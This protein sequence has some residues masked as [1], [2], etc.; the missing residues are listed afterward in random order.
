MVIVPNTSKETAFLIAERIRKSI[1]T[2]PICAYDEKVDV[3][4]SIGLSSYPDEAKS[5]HDLVGKADWALYQ[6]K[7]IGKN[8]SCCFGVFHE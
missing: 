8:K 3:T 6:A 7:K 4:V 1:E 5:V 2:G